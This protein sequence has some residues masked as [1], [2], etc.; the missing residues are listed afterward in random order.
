MIQRAPGLLLLASL[1]VASASPLAAKTIEVPIHWSIQKG[2]IS[3][4]RL[5]LMAGPKLRKEICAKAGASLRAGDTVHV[6]I[7]GAGNQLITAFTYTKRDC[8]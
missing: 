1:I 7:Y 3:I 8:Q 5:R 6:S 2:E 4:A